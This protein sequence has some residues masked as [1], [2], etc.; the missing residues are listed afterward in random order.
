MAFPAG[1]SGIVG[2]DGKWFVDQCF[3]EEKI[4]YADLDLEEVVREKLSLDTA[5]HY[6]RPDV[7]QLMV[8]DQPKEQIY[9]RSQNDAAGS[10]W[11]ASLSDTVPSRPEV[12]E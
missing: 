5:G 4:I 2:P 3:Y 1:G 11:T 10:G 7:F 12:S 9:W 6:N 8:D